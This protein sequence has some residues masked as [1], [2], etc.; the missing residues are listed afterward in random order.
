[1]LYEFSFIDKIKRLND[2]KL[3]ERHTI[4][5]CLFSPFSFYDFNEDCSLP[6]KQKSSTHFNV[7]TFFNHSI[8]LAFTEYVCNKNSS[9]SPRGVKFFF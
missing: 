2:K 1:M 6:C 5:H 7:A 3:K 4:A 9:V 8:Y